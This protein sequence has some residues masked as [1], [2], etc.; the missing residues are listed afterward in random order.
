MDKRIERINYIKS[1]FVKLQEYVTKKGEPIYGSRSNVR[2]IRTFVP[3]TGKGSLTSTATTLDRDPDEARFDRA[4]RSL[5][6][7]RRSAFPEPVNPLSAEKKDVAGDTTDI[8]AKAAEGDVKTIE[9]ELAKQPKASFIPKSK[10][11][12]KQQIGSVAKGIGLT[13]KGLGKFA[14]YYSLANRDQFNID[15]KAMRASNRLKY[16]S[17]SASIISR[18]SEARGGPSVSAHLAKSGEGLGQVRVFNPTT[19]KLELRKQEETLVGDNARSLRTMLAK[20]HDVGPEGRDPAFDRGNAVTNLLFGRGQSQG[21]GQIN[22]SVGSLGDQDKGPDYSIFGRGY[23]GRKDAKS[24]QKLAS[25]N[26]GVGTAFPETKAGV[27]PFTT[28]ASQAASIALSARETAQERSKN[29][30]TAN[31]RLNRIRTILPGKEGADLFDKERIGYYKTRRDYL[32]KLKFNSMTNPAVRGIQAIR[33]NKRTRALKTFDTGAGERSKV[34]S[35]ATSAASRV[36]R[37]QSVPGRGYV[38]RSRV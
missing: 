30:D 27:D 5:E 35:I 2:T 22:T 20:S 28:S 13:A 25:K 26:P 31:L 12:L 37:L 18:R 3:V 15:Q 7:A 36:R 11:E 6:L 32:E 19:G 14:A 34:L 9:T 23:Y 8:L 1:I 38:I 10:S 4:D 29:T 24:W 33:G 17:A 21:E 16:G